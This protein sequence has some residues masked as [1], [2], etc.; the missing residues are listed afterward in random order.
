MDTNCLIC[1]EPHSTKQCPERKP[2]NCPDCAVFIKNFSDHTSLCGMKTWIFTPYPDLYATPPLERFIIGCNS[3]IRF[4][5]GG[6]WQKPS[7]GDE[8]YSPVS[9]VLVRFSNEKDF[10]VLTGKFAPIRIAFVVKENSQFVIKLMLLASKQRFLV[11]T[12]VNEPFDRNDAEKKHQWKTTLIVTAV[13]S[14]ENLCF[15]VLAM[16]PRQLSMRYE[17]RYDT[18]MKK[19]IIPHDLDIETSL[20]E[21]QIVN[22]QAMN[23]LA[24]PKVKNTDEIST[25]I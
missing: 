24:L 15:D 23:Q 14:T 12:D 16:P 1:L 3:P 18:S 17:L 4:L 22:R 6:I 9:G 8:V 11:A 10:T 7:D 25:I 2:Q 20:S 21:N 13:S 5:L 19:F